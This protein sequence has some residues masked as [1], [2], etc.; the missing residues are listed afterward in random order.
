MNRELAMNPK[1][2]RDLDN[3]EPKSEGW[4]GDFPFQ[5][6]DSQVP[7]YIFGCVERKTSP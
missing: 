1:T 3:I 7:Y 6:G 2:H 5:R 4:E